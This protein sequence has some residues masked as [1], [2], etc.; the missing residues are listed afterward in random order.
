MKAGDMH[1]LAFVKAAS[2]RALHPGIKM[3]LSAPS[4]ARV[5]GEPLQH[6]RAV[7]LRAVRFAGDQIVY[8]EISLDRQNVSNDESRYAFNVAAVCYVRQH[9]AM[10]LRLLLNA[11][12]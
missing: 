8:I 7:S 10:L 3:Q 2:L 9:V 12:Q 4:L 1:S 6:C 5:G 11:R